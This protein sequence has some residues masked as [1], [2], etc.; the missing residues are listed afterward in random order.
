M[1]DTSFLSFDASF[2]SCDA[3]FLSSNASFLSSNAS[4]LSSNAS[5][6][7]FDASL[8][9]HQTIDI[10]LPYAFPLS[11]LDRLE[12]TGTGSDSYPR[13]PA[14]C[15]SV[16]VF[17]SL[18][19]SLDACSKQ[20]FPNSRIRLHLQ[21]KRERA[22]HDVIAKACVKTRRA[23]DVTGAGCTDAPQHKVSR[24]SPAASGAGHR[25]RAAGRLRPPRRHLVR[26]RHRHRGA[27]L[28]V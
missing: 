7:S 4:F 11:R 22:W 16:A 20:I 13:K 15:R 27:P 23:D 14:C 10:S 24:Q 25:G 19:K 26:G 28:R 17:R 9:L 6:L 2:L 3:S 21:P 12:G 5:F 8:K 18:C 1:S